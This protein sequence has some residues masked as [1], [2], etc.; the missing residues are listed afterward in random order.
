M[1]MPA[2]CFT[3]NTTKMTMNVLLIELSALANEMEAMGK[4]MLSMTSRL[5]H[6]LDRIANKNLAFEEAKRER[7]QKLE[8]KK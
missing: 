2:A 3:W 6:Q 7:M 1:D 8:E 5:E 4:R